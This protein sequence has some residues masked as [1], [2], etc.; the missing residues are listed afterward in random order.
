[1]PKTKPLEAELVAIMRADALELTQ[2]AAR[3][4]TVDL[5]DVNEATRQAR[6]R[7]DRVRRARARADA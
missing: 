6:A 7:R 5:D 2:R 1:M 4:A 3:Q